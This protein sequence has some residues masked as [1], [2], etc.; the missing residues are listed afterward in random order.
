MCVCVW[1]GGLVGRHMKIDIV[2][3]VPR[4]KAS[5]T[6]GYTQTL[7]HSHLY[8]KTHTHTPV[9]PAAFRGK[10]TTIQSRCEACPQ[11]ALCTPRVQVRDDGICL[12]VCGCIYPRLC[13]GGRRWG[14]GKHPHAR[15]SVECAHA[16][17]GRGECMCACEKVCVSRV[18]V[19]VR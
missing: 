16:R 8:Y 17:A 7:A 11:G 12:W 6:L 18:R 10:Q 5:Q 2:H 4:L 19:P 9:H 1:V 14:R 3:P 15:L 13:A